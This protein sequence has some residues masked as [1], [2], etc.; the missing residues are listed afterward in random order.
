MLEQTMIYSEERGTWNLIVN[1]EWYF[2]GTW[3]Q[4]EQMMFDNACEE[5]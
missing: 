2:E 3:E 1:G 5:E 4:C